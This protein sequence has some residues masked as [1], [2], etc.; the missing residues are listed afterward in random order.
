MKIRMRGLGRTR[1]IGCL[2]LTV[3]AL[4]LLVGTATARPD[5]TATNIHLSSK[6]P[7]FHGTVKSRAHVCVANR[8]VQ[9][10]RKDPAGDVLIGSD[11]ADDHGSWIVR[12]PNFPSG[13]YYAKAVWWTNHPTSKWAIICLSDTSSPVV[14]D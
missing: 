9:V 1:A 12:H 2:G 10:F 6:A 4:A 3:T 7:A 8:K 14:V 11:R 5:R 13:E